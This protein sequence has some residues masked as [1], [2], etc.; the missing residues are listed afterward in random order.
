MQRQLDLPLR[1]EHGRAPAVGSRTASS[2]SNPPTAG[3][4]TPSLTPALTWPW[5]HGQASVI[6][7]EGVRAL[8]LDSGRAAEPGRAAW[9]GRF[10]RDARTR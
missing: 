7:V 10:C 6:S 8:V 4:W 5:V 2:T 3:T 9:P 1:A